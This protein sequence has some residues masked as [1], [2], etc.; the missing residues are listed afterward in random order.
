MRLAQRLEA[1]NNH[2]T[3]SL[4]VV[5]LGLGKQLP[6]PNTCV[7]TGFRGTG[8]HSVPEVCAFL[9]DNW[10]APDGLAADV[11]SAGT[12]LKFVLP[13]AVKSKVRACCDYD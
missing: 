7:V 11:Y 6:T 9:Q 3:K 12:A 1:W 13:G 8:A 2:D 10:A 4:I 5:G